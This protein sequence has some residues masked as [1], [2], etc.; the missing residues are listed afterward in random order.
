VAV[1]D[2]AVPP[3]TGPLSLYRAQ[4]DGPYTET[5]ALLVKLVGGAAVWVPKQ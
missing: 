3:P 2:V 4:L 5:P 1:D